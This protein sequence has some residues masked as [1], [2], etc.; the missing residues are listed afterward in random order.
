VTN[1][2][3]VWR[4]FPHIFPFGDTQALEGEYQILVEDALN[5]LSGEEERNMLIDLLDTQWIAF[6][7]QQFLL[8]DLFE[9][10]GQDFTHDAP[11]ALARIQINDNIRNS[12][13]LKKMD[14]RR[15]VFELLSQRTILDTLEGCNQGG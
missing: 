9:K 7:E 3:S 10:G 12:K 13:G 15:M 5:R 1:S 11:I 4:D 2:L 6:A 14:V 8:S